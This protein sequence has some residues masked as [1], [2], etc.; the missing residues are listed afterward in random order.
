[1]SLALYRRHLAACPH[2]DKGRQFTKCSCSI[3]VDGINERDGLPVRRSLETRDWQRAIRKLA[4]LED[5]RAPQVKSVEEAIAAFE[6]HLSIES[7]TRRKYRNVLRHL[8]EHLERVGVE[9]V[10]QVIVERLDS[11]RASRKLSPVTSTKE[12]QTL[13]QFFGFC[14][15]R[16]WIEDNPAKRI[17]PP[18]NIKPAEVVPYTDAEIERILAACSQMGRADYER[19]RARAMVL[20][21]YYTALRI[22]DVAMLERD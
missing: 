9:D 12:L 8:R 1:M 18:R 5:P 16:R 17:K 4:A 2:R 21:L 11:Y 10:M 13:R 19:R 3:W 15:E 20:L 14:Q 22:S 7:S 6:N